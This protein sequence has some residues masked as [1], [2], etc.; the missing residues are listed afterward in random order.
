MNGDLTVPDGGWIKA[1]SAPG[2]GNIQLESDGDVY[3]P[4]DLQVDGNVGIGR[5]PTY[6]LDVYTS[7]G[8]TKIVCESTDDN[9]QILIHANEGGTGTGGNEDPRL[10]FATA[11]TYE[12]F[13]M[14]HKDT[15]ALCFGNATGDYDAIVMDVDNVRLGIGKDPTADLDVYVA[16]GNVNHYVTTDDASGASS[17]RADAD[18][19]TYITIQAFGDTYAAGSYFGLSRVGASFCRVFDGAMGIGTYDSY[20]LY[21]GTNNN[22]ALVIDTSQDARFYGDVGIGGTPYSALSFDDTTST[23]TATPTQINMGGTY[24]STTGDDAK[25]KFVIYDGGGSS[26]TGMGLSS[27]AWEFHNNQTTSKWYYVETL[28]AELTHGGTATTWSLYGAGGA[29]AGPA[30]LELLADAGED[31]GDG[32]RIRAEDGGTLVFQNDGTGSYV[33]QVYFTTT[34]VGIGTSPSYPLHIVDGNSSFW[35]TDD[36]TNLTM[37]LNNDNTGDAD[38]YLYLDCNDT[39]EADIHFRSGGSGKWR[40]GSGAA[41]GNRLAFY[42]YGGFNDEMVYFESDNTENRNMVEILGPCGI[43]NNPQDGTEYLPVVRF[44]D[45]VTDYGSGTATVGEYRGGVEWYSSETSSNMPAITAAIYSINLDTYNTHTGLAFLVNDNTASPEC[46]MILH[47]NGGLNIAYDGATVTTS[48]SYALYLNMQSA[49]GGARFYSGSTD[50]TVTIQG[51]ESSDAIL[52]MWADQGDDTADK[53]SIKSQSAGNIMRFDYNDGA[54]NAFYYNSTGDFYSPAI[55]GNSGSSSGDVVH[56][57]SN[58]IGIDS[59]SR[60][61]K[62][63]IQPMED[64]WSEKIW[65]LNPVTYRARKQ[66]KEKVYTDPNNRSKGYAVKHAILDE[67]YD[68]REIG[69]IAEDAHDLG[70]TE[71]VYYDENG[72]VQSFNYRRYGA[73]LHNEVKKLRQ[74][75]L[76]LETNYG[77]LAIDTLR[78]SLDNLIDWRSETDK[79]IERLETENESLK[80]RVEELEAA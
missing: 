8:E 74:R 22:T 24:G 6:N 64:S 41:W 61:Y 78:S 52:E 17:I 72:E 13:I 18:S 48:T 37:Y 31:N 25:C 68:K 7:A 15:E 39:G 46:R 23:S 63:D 38:T 42:S 65:G 1:V 21:L 43:I 80:K 59:S 12:A 57:G 11:G 10:G 19:D 56:I 45:T 34:G 20:D 66:T 3:M 73:I 75:T 77:T 26:V 55:T 50:S 40:I 51:Y 14:Y 79:K 70:L 58:Q 32:W 27:G 67:L 60:R 29:S 5:S 71:L 44:R 69:F 54:S 33:D 2:S 47:N 76:Q 53:F 28:K 16:T 4:Q 36:G 9:A 49:P 62:G 30:M 35:V